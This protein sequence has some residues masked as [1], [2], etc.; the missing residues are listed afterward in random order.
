MGIGFDNFWSCRE[1]LHQIWAFWSFLKGF[2][3]VPSQSV[4]SLTFCYIELTSVTDIVFSLQLGLP[5]SGSNAFVLTESLVNTRAES[6]RGSFFETMFRSSCSE[7]FLEIS[8][9][10]QENTCARVSFLE[11]LAQEFS[12]ELCEIS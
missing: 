11:T 8:Q 3:E 4:L 1:H 5:V 2:L 9:D 10:S 7:V 6:L 12:C